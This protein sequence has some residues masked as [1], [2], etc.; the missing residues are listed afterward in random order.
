MIAGD[1]VTVTVSVDVPPAR[2]FAVFTDEI[3]LWWRRGPA[4]RVAGRRPGTLAFEP[5]L[6]GRLFEQYEG[7][8]G[9]RVHEAGTIVVW[10]P[11]ARLAFDWRGSNFAPGEVTR[12]DITFTA[13]DSGTRVV[14]EHSGF[15]ALRPDHP[16]RHGQPVV[17]FIRSIGMWWGQLLS[18]MR[19]QA[20]P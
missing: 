2:A 3:D 12:V 7:P 6:G 15:A 13:T 10:E 1:K 11:G 5:K 18:A 16:V 20:E 14:L 4:Y 19:D 8:D 17:V 9:T